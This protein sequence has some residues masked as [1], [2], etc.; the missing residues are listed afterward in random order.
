M[1]PTEL[2]T[3]ASRPPYNKVLWNKGSDV[4]ISIHDPP[5]KIYQE[6]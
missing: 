3:P 6:T 2:A 4:I 1:I 5:T